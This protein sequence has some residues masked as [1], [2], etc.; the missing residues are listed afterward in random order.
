[1]ETGGPLASALLALLH[2]GALEELAWTC[3]ALDVPATRGRIILRSEFMSHCPYRGSLFRLRCQCDRWPASTDAGENGAVDFNF[4]A[5]SMESPDRFHGSVSV[6][7]VRRLFG[8]IREQCLNAIRAEARGPLFPQTGVGPV[9]FEDILDLVRNHSPGRWRWRQVTRIG[10]AREFERT[11]ETRIDA[12]Q[13]TLREITGV[14][15]GES[16]FEAEI[17]WA[18][19][20]GQ[21][22]PALDAAQAME[23]VALVKERA[24]TALRLKGRVRPA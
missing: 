17:E 12:L 10:E 5:E 16:R 6:N 24:Q 4:S 13:F 14:E 18:S 11:Y 15:T 20:S 3:E 23:L 19:T 21:P 9:S 8:L 22:Q 2:G 7:D 1:M